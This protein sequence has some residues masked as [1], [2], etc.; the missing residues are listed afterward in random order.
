MKT[1]VIVQQLRKAGKAHRKCRILYIKHA[2]FASDSVP[3]KRVIA[4]YEID[5]DYVLATD[6]K[7]GSAKIKSF[8]I[9]NIQSIEI[10]P[11]KFKPV[12]EIKL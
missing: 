11:S 3:T 2:R 1:A 8:I 10:L 4:P 9:K 5:G 6:Q 12:W 7:D